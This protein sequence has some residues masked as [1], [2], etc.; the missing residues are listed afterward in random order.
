M[1]QSPCSIIVATSFA[2][3][4]G[5]QIGDPDKAA[6]RVPFVEDLGG[7]VVVLE[8]FVDNGPCQAS[9]RLVQVDNQLADDL[10]VAEGDDARAWLESRVGDKTRDETRVQ[11]A[12]IPQR[13]P[14]RFARMR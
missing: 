10:A 4:F 9:V 7:G 5:Q 14:D 12:D 11:R 1:T 6:A 3:S 8:G 13:I 2:N